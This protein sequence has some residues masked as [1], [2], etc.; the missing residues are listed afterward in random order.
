MTWDTTDVEYNNG[1][2]FFNQIGNF[3]DSIIVPNTGRYSISYSVPFTSVVVRPTVRFTMFLNGV[4]IRGQTTNN[5][6][7]NGAGGSLS[8]SQNTNILNLTSGDR[9]DIRTQLTA[10]AGNVTVNGGAGTGEAYFIFQEL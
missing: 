9:V 1:Y 2:T 3:C 5:Y 7:R 10:T 6:I 4:L 8:S